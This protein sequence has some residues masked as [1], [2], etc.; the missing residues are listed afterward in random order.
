ML[1]YL[2][3]TNMVQ[4]W[5]LFGVFLFH[6]ADADI[7]NRWL[8]AQQYKCLERS[9]SLHQIL[10]MYYQCLIKATISCNKD[11]NDYH[12]YS[13]IHISQFCTFIDSS[14]LRY[15]PTT[16][17]VIVNPAILII[18][19]KFSLSHQNWLCTRS[20]FMIIKKD[21]VDRY[22]GE[23]YPWIY[24]AP[25]KHL[26]FYFSS[27]EFEPGTD[28][29]TL[30]YYSYY[31]LYHVQY[32]TFI[33]QSNVMNQVNFGRKDSD[34]EI[35]IIARD[36]L[37]YIKL[38][39]SGEQEAAETVI[40]YD[41][42][43]HLSPIIMP[44]NLTHHQI[45]STYQ[46]NFYQM[47]CRVNHS[48]HREGVSDIVFTSFP[49]NI[50]AC[51]DL[52]YLPDHEEIS[53]ND[54]IENGV[55]QI[56]LDLYSLP[57]GNCILN[58][59]ASDVKAAG[60]EIS[61]YDVGSFY[62]WFYDLVAPQMLVE[63]EGCVY[64]GLHI[65][66]AKT[67]ADVWNY[68]SEGSAPGASMAFN[69][70]DF[71]ILIQTF[72]GYSPKSISL[73]CTIALSKGKLVHLGGVPYNSTTVQ[74]VPHFNYRNSITNL[75][76]DQQTEKKHQHAY[77]VIATKV[78][79]EHNLKDEPKLNIKRGT[80]NFKLVLPLILGSY[81][82]Y[83]DLVMVSKPYDFQAISIYPAEGTGNVFALL[84]SVFE[85]E[86]FESECISCFVYSKDVTAFFQQSERSINKVQPNSYY[87]YIVAANEIEIKS[88]SCPKLPNWLL[89][90]QN[91]HYH[92]KEDQLANHSIKLMLSASEV[93]AERM[94]GLKINYGQ[95]WWFAAEV[96]DAEADGTYILSTNSFCDTEQ[97]YLEHYI[98]GTT[99]RSFIFKWERQESEM[100]IHSIMT[101]TQEIWIRGCSPCNILFRGVYK[102]NRA[103]GF[104]K[105]TIIRRKLNEWKR[106]MNHLK[107]YH[108]R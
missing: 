38:Q 2:Q 78:P 3:F 105:L 28:Y 60:I 10:K 83:A 34:A 4:L 70:Q 52:T 50:P 53:F 98:P 102:T 104:C 51:P 65:L 79:N 72:S 91:V 49:S 68:C 5:L 95:A 15:N 46:S 64:G 81:Y 19:S 37:H 75:T 32:A 66:S 41:G 20:Q 45:N 74:D 73:W 31:T 29:F 30:Q 36:K 107:L 43:G 17:D 13:I 1:Y 59:S 16:W 18:F 82:I 24:H 56:H 63:G 93:S 42:P 7:E 69:L 103:L 61:D 99:D 35:H 92:I 54:G 26:R 101:Q 90:I 58:S 87:S 12:V 57:A 6:V 94:I 21:T 106:Q 14:N 80:Q 9:N 71:I 108:I 22:C 85:K 23:R 33:I 77:T 76:D 84:F 39:I 25:Q 89:I 8:R 62:L 100:S 44:S 86:N 67:S 27:D 97:V 48:M 88:Q 40:C 96:N 55:S 47:L 11:I